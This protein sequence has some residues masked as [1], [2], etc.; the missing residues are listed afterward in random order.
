MDPIRYINRKTK[1]VELEKIYGEKAIR[2]LYS[3]KSYLS[4]LLC[5]LLAHFSFFS[6]FYGFLQKRSASKKKIIPFIQNYSVNVNEF[7]NPVD[8]FASFNDFFIRKLKKESRPIAKGDDLAIIPADGRYLFYPNIEKADGFVVK[9]KKF[10]IEKLLNSKE[11]SKTFDQASLVIARLCPLDYH[12]FHFPFGGIASETTLI[13]GP[14]Y[15]VN[16]IALKHNVSI[17]AENKRTY[18]LL[19]TKNHGTI[20]YMEV[21][22]TSVGSIH[23]T[24]K[25]NQEVEK[26]EEKGYFSFGGSTL[27][28]LFEK[29]KIQF[30]QDLIE[31]TLDSI[32]IY[33][34][35]GESMG[36][37]R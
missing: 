7:L 18:T 23:Q 26:G 10:T 9:G 36:V 25:A 14:L 33:C 31:A 29:D 20:L 15:S 34:K 21:G 16:P 35:M 4:T 27:I 28:L 12:R 32:E 19:K 2:F 1:Q 17:L 8:S 37:L 3:N 11:L 6:S 13:N 22:A 24:Y 5:R 30:D